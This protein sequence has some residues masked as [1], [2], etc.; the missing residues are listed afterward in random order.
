[1]DIL[2][3]YKSLP[4]NIKKIVSE[5][6]KPIHSNRFL[7]S[8]ESLK[9]DSKKINFDTKWNNNPQKF[10]LD[11]Y[12]YAEY[13]LVVLLVNN[14]KSIFEFNLDYIKESIILA[15]HEYTIINTIT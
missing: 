14:L 11:Y 13:Y 8:I 2:H 15:P 7:N 10:A 4:P 6:T 9:Q 3:Q 12:G 1:M 5:F